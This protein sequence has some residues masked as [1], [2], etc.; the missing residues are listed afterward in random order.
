MKKT[1]NQIIS[2]NLVKYSLI[3][4]V[5]SAIAISVIGVNSAL[6]R[7]VPSVSGG[8]GGGGGSDPY[9]PRTVK[10]EL[11]CTGYK[12]L[13]DDKCN[14]KG[15][16]THEVTVT[17]DVCAKLHNVTLTTTVPN[18]EAAIN[19]WKQDRIVEA[20]ESVGWCRAPYNTTPG[21]TYK[22]NCDQAK[23]DPAGA[24]SAQQYHDKSE[25]AKKCAKYDGKPYD[26]KTMAN[27]VGPNGVC[28][29]ENNVMNCG[30]AKKTNVDNGYNPDGSGGPGASGTPGTKNPSRAEGPLSGDG[31]G[32]DPVGDFLGFPAWNRDVHFSPGS[33]IGP[34]VMK[35]V[36]NIT[37][38]LLRLAGIAAVIVIIYAGAMFIIG[39]Y[40]SS[41]DGIAKAKTILING[42]IGLII[43]IAATAIVS[44]IAGSL[45]GK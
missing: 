35:I 5:I 29:Q 15:N 4:T 40:S 27:C 14:L 25:K 39:S 26:P 7:L 10:L 18:G 34:Q 32:S 24:E 16:T 13:G 36:L 19:W 11:P 3:L 17:P 2:F 21:E 9:G 38:I 8:D 44:F 33:E 23:N 22:E 28:S 20:C 43:A 12:E 1:K 31:I 41:P 42:V 45:K 37:E 30:G 6:A